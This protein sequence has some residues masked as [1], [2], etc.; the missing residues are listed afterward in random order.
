MIIHCG[1]SGTTVQFIAKQEVYNNPPAQEIKVQDVKSEPQKEIKLE[2]KPEPKVELKQA[3][4]EPEP[5]N[6]KYAPKKQ[7]FIVTTADMGG[8]IILTEDSKNCYE[9]KY[10][11]AVDW[12]HKTY[13]GCWEMIGNRININYGNG[14]HYSYEYDKRVW[15]TVLR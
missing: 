12:Q 2:P 4:V 7:K 8:E 10:M 6:V 11:F 3:L 14:E 13:P 1:G 9:K 15:K 5:V